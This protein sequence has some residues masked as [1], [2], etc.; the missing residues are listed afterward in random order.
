VLSTLHTNSA[1]D[2]ITRLLDIG[3]EPFVVAN[4]LIAVVSQRLLRRLCPQ[5]CRPAAAPAGVEEGGTWREAGECEACA[6]TGYRGRVGVFEI[7]APDDDLR[8]M[9]KRKPS[10]RELRE[11]L[12]GAGGVTLR[13]RAVEC[14]ARGLTSMDEVLRLT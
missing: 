14:A 11:H 3:L 5:C 9:I 4:A 2:T 8:E 13:A 7:L 6:R 10:T 1:V 12:A